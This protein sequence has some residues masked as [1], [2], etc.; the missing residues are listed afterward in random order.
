[1]TFKFDRMVLAPDSRHVALLSTDTQDQKPHL[2]LAEIE[3]GKIVRD[4]GEH[5]QLP[6]MLCFSPEGKELVSLAKERNHPRG[7][8]G[9]TCSPGR[10]LFVE[11]HPGLGYQRGQGRAARSRLA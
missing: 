9:A 1:V 5:P 3:S 6:L 10:G 11:T 8:R 2:I 7:G 4:F